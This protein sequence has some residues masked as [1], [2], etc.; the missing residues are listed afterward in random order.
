M[1]QLQEHFWY[2]PIETKAHAERICR[3]TANGFL[4]CALAMLL[5]H[6]TFNF[7]QSVGGILLGVPALLLRQSSNLNAARTL[8]GISIFMLGMSVLGMADELYNRQN[9]FIVLP[10]FLIW[11]AFLRATL[12]ACVGG[13]KVVCSA[14]LTST[15][16]QPVYRVHVESRESFV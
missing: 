15:D 2:G 4:L 6:P 7:S 10:L 8:A 9:I 12:R 14:R 16:Y 1:E 13:E 11:T 5:P 3:Y